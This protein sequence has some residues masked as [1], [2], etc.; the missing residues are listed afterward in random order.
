MHVRRLLLAFIAGLLTLTAVGCGDQAL[1]KGDQAVADS[2]ASYAIE[3]SDGVWN[4]LEAQCMAEHFVQ[5]AGVDAL[6]EAGL[7]SPSGQAVAAKVA[8]PRPLATKFAD[9]VLACVDFADL[10]AR[11][12][13]NARPDIKTAAFTACVRKSITKPQARDRLIAQQMNDT[14]ASAYLKTNAAM[15]KCAEAAK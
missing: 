5:A 4:K 13:A 1:S 3:Q 7:V 11:Q 6:K 9:S 8:L 14:K 12:I 15:L 2:L 10:T